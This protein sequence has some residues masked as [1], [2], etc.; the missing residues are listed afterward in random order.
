MG[1]LLV[2]RDVSKVSSKVPE[3]WVVNISL[4]PLANVLHDISSSSIVESRGGGAI[5]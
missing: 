1:D 4:F 2:L 3:D 5:F